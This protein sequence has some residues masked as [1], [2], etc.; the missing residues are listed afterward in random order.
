[1]RDENWTIWC[2]YVWQENSCLYIFTGTVIWIT[3]HLLAAD[4]RPGFQWKL[5]TYGGRSHLY[6]LKLYIWLIYCL[7]EIRDVRAQSQVSSK[8]QFLFIYYV[9]INISQIYTFWTEIKG[10]H[11]T[12]LVWRT[13]IVFPF[14][15]YVAIVHLL[16]IREDIGICWNQLQLGFPW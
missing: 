1:M 8:G 13:H 15:L 10:Y 12:R 7:I 6:L 2:G 14:F 16:Q 5:N 4:N 9:Q 11:L 3:S